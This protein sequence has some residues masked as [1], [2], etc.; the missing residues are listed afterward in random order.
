MTT[1]LWAA[2]CPEAGYCHYIQPVFWATKK[3]EDA[4]RHWLEGPLYENR[5]GDPS[6]PAALITTHGMKDPLMLRAVDLLSRARQ[7]PEADA[8]Y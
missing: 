4:L 3:V 8:V 5:V 1:S 7:Q 6:V 2:V